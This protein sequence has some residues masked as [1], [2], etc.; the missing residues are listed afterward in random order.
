MKYIILLLII[1]LTIF[2]Q[3]WNTGSLKLEWNQELLL[4]KSTMDGIAGVIVRKDVNMCAASNLS[5]THIY[6]FNSTTKPVE[7]YSIST[8]VWWFDSFDN[9]LN[10]REA[11]CIKTRDYLTGSILENKCYNIESNWP[12]TSP[13]SV[14]LNGSFYYAE[15]NLLCKFDR[16]TNLSFKKQ[17]DDIGSPKYMRKAAGRIFLYGL[18]GNSQEARLMQYDTLG[19]QN[20]SL[21]PGNLTNIFIDSDGNSYIIGYHPQENSYLNKLNP[22]G[23]TVWTKEIPGQWIWN[24]NIVGD[25][26]YLVGMVA[27]N[28]TKVQPGAAITILSKESTEILE[29]YSYDFYQGDQGYLEQF[30][31]VAVDDIGSVY[32]GGYSG[33]Y[34]ICFL[35]KLSKEGNT[36]GIKTEKDNGSG[37]SIFPNPGNSK[38]TIACEQQNTGTLKVTIRN[39]LGQIIQKKEYLCDGHKS[40]ELDL[41]KQPAGNYSIEIL[42]GDEKIV[43]KVVVE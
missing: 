20:W 30:N 32:A 37:F 17:I 31:Q 14:F 28:N 23:Q 34:P 18:Y 22:Q 3:S 8:L 10:S 40:W 29:Q 36:T 27:H 39:A 13:V 26:I 11:N 4:P 16:L 38:F 15:Y 19:N 43:K 7:S 9:K 41:G 35:A 42:A 21:D 24:G 1:P 5:G 2:P 12:A 33:I 6:T 25:R